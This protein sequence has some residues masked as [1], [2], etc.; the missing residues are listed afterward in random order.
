MKKTILTIAAAMGASVMSAA[1]PEAGVPEVDVRQQE[2]LDVFEEICKVPRYSS[3]EVRIGNW[4]TT[5]AATNGFA[6]TRDTVGNVIIEV[7]ATPGMENRELVVLQTHQDMVRAV[8]EGVQHSWETE[9]IVPVVEDG[10][11]HSENFN[12]SLGADDGIG[13]ATVLA[14]VQGDAPHGPLRLI[15]TV[16]EE[17]TQIGVKQLDTNT[18]ADA[19]YLINVD[20]LEEGVVTI[21]SACADVNT[22]IRTPTCEAAPSDQYKTFKIEVSGLRGGH[23]GIDI[24][25]GRVNAIIALGK[26]LRGLKLEELKLSSLTGGSAVNAIPAF[27]SAVIM[28]PE[29][30]GAGVSTAATALQEEL[31]QGDEEGAQ[32]SATEVTSPEKV[33]SVS[34]RD[35]L[36][37]LV[38]GL[39]NGVVTMSEVIPN[40]VQTSSN[41]GSVDADAAAGKMQVV[42]MMRSSSE[43][44][45]KQLLKANEDL[46]KDL[47]FGWTHSK[48]CEIWPADPHS[49]LLTICTNVYKTAFDKDISVIATHAG[50]ECGT[51]KN[52]NPALDIISIGPTVLN[53]HSIAERCDFNSCLKVRNLLEGILLQI[54]E[55]VV[56]LPVITFFEPD[57]TQGPTTQVPNVSWKIAGPFDRVALT[58]DKTTVY[59][60]NDRNGEGR[61]R[62]LCNPGTH[63]LK[64]TV[65]YGDEEVTSSCF[66]TALLEG[67]EPALLPMIG[68]FYPDYYVGKKGT[69]PLVH[70][71]TLNIT[72]FEIWLDGTCILM[73]QNAS[74]EFRFSQLNTPGSYVVRMV[75]HNAIDDAEAS[76]CYRCEA[77]VQDQLTSA[78]L[79]GSADQPPVILTFE[80]DAYEASIRQTPYIRW[81]L[82]APVDALKLVIDDIPVFIGDGKEGSGRWLDVSGLNLGELTGSH[83]VSLS[84]SNSFGVATSNFTCTCYWEEPPPPPKG[85]EENPWAIGED[86]QAYT[87]GSGGLIVSGSG[88]TSNYTD[89]AMV[90]WAEVVNEIETVEVSD[91]VEVIGDNLWAGLAEDVGINGE[92]IMRRKEIA[93]G[94]PAEDPSGAI[95]PAEFERIDIIDGKALL[96]VSVYTSD[97]LTNENWSV[98]TNGVIEVPAPGKQGFFILKSKPAGK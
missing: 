55:R 85:S 23:S 30:V 80:P 89:A 94:F 41:L 13:M 93:A 25:D 43:A 44:D 98:A 15:M 66:Y 36:L 33:L 63:R 21:S 90:P 2:V 67:G 27:A 16:E 37:A 9:P 3:F 78:P 53:E 72:S 29:E 54:P 24:N 14:V 26:L 8:K 12:T 59:E 28:V 10:W 22:F 4:L 46:A 74:G 77:P 92:T 95:S 61:W 19:K 88:A 48:N 71:D 17:T 58:I 34:D 76:F 45:Y 65:G 47:G 20:F 38:T 5:W 69:A 40:L 42:A 60:G 86:V 62:D 32:V 50:L 35:A 51:F 49:E 56:P 97:T 39:T 1:E 6:S 18:V 79:L 87:N 75:A 96:D 68:Y 70:W 73:S 7:P 52:K 84:V 11:I 64:L 82:S 31:L 57:F 91:A 81:D 83:E